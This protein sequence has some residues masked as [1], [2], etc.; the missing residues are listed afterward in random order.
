[1]MEKQIAKHN[2]SRA[3]FAS[4]SIKFDANTNRLPSVVSA[5][6]WGRP[7]KGGYVYFFL[8]LIQSSQETIVVT[9]ELFII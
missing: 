5:D 1:M 2:T 8:C 7:I 4:G 9:L 3:P 6:R